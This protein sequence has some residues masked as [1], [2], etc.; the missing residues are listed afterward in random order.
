MPPLSELKHQL[1]AYNNKQVVVLASGDPLYYGI[2]RWF[3]QHFA[4]EQLVF[5]PAISSIQA[6]C[7]Q[8]GLSL[9]DVTVMSLHGRP[10]EKIRTQLH[11]NTKLLVLTDKYSQ[12]Q[13][14]AKECIAA[15]FTQSTLTV[16]ENLG[17]QTQSI[18]SFSAEQLAQ[19][20]SLEFD[21]LHLTVIEVLGTGGIL[22]EF[23]GIADTAYITG[24]SAGKGMISKREVR[25]VILSLLQPSTDDI[26]WDIGAGCGGVT[27]ELAYW[28]EQATIF[29]IEHHQERLQYLSAN[30]QRFGV[31]HNVNI[32][33]GRAPEALANL[34]KPHKIFIG[35]SDGELTSL[36]ETSWQILPIGGVLVASAVMETTRSQLVHFVETTSSAIVESVEVSIKRG[37]LHSDG[38]GKKLQYQSRLPVEI[39]QLKKCAPEI[40][41]VNIRENKA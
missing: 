1:K 39:F 14:L 25:L 33:A 41:P 40:Q 18:R 30:C 19:D 34:P 36:L 7:H 27:V 11:G 9:Q 2:G 5:Y 28:N 37:E 31:T 20:T 3:C 23:P 29:A 15:G 24:K 21:P 10:L 13:V 8:L 35:G 26:I 22:P 16:C 38:A 12:P 6:A 17:Y 4:R 32:V